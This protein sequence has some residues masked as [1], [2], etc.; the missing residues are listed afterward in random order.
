MTPKKE[1]TVITFETYQRTYLRKKVETTV[2]CEFCSEKTLLVT[3][4]VAAHI[5]QKSVTVIFRMV[6]EGKVHFFETENGNL[7][8]C[9]NSLAEELSE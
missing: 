1:K 4:D 5:F 9:S 8:I 7:Q 2:W 6:E 3:P